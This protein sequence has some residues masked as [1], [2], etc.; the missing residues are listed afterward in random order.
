[1]KYRSILLFTSFLI[2]S[3]VFSQNILRGTVK[4]DLSNPI[5]DVNLVIQ[6][7]NYYA[8][9]NYDG[10]YSIY[11]IPDGA[12][13][14]VVSMIGF[15]EKEILINL[16]NSQ[17]LR[18]DLILDEGVKLDEVII[19]ARIAG[20]ANAL[21]TQKNRGNMVSIISKE[22][23]ERFPDANIGDALKRIAGINVQYDQGEA[24]FANIRGTAPELNS[25][26]IN[27]ERIPSAEGDKRSVQLDLIPA[28]MIE[29]IELNKAITPDMDADAI[30]GSINLITKKAPS[31]QRIKG[32]IG[33][34]YSVLAEKLLYK[35]KLSYSNRFKDDK[36]GLILSVS[37]LD[38]QIRSDNVEAEWDYTDENQTAHTAFT[39]DMQIRK[40]G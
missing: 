39:S 16:S 14:L 36:I 3:V 4:D 7:T 37:V 5:P 26:T 10:K 32:T 9:T 1:M 40:Y 29:T 31:K 25:V 12:Y 11:N 18:Q 15:S 24:R 34:G 23:I 6:N 20:Q 13:K 21:N 30:G 27:G 2:S 33:S 28:D 22:Q 17:T 38:K 8:T 19:N 35:G